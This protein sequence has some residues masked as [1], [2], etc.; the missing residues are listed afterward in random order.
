[1]VA[2]RRHEAWD[3]TAS[4]IAAVYQTANTEEGNV[5]YPQQFHPGYVSTGEPDEQTLPVGAVPQKMVFGMMRKAFTDV[6]SAAMGE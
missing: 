6:N 1:M 4:I 5:F 2:F 3:H